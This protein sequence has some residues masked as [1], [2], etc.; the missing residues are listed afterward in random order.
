[1]IE[2]PRE[3]LG[4][5]G[6]PSAT[7]YGLRFVSIQLYIRIFVGI[8]LELQKSANQILCG[9]TP[10][11]ESRRGARGE[12]YLWQSSKLCGGRK[13]HCNLEMV[14]KIG[15]IGYAGDWRAPRFSTKRQYGLVLLV[16][17]LPSSS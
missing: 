12:D 17:L 8:N 6:L 7:T 11:I 10:P 13:D 15:E 3:K 4:E 16:S 14:N 9:P 1:M 5:P 2:S